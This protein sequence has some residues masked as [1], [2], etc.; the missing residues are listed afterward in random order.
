MQQNLGQRL[1]YLDLLRILATFAV[2]FLHACSTN[3]FF[4]CSNTSNWYITLIGDSLVRW[5][6][7]VFVMISGAL[8]LNP[9]RNVT[10]RDILTKRI[11]R[12][13][14]A[15]VFWTGI[16]ILQGYTYSGFEGF[17]V[18]RFLK[19]SAHSTA[20]LWFLPMLMG[21][22]FLIPVLHTITRDKK[23]MR[24]VLV[25]WIVL[26]FVSFLRFVELFKEMNHFY[27]LFNMNTVAGFSGYFIL[28]YYLSRQTFSKRQRMWIYLIG[29]AGALITIF[30]TIYISTSK[31]GG[32]ELFFNYFSIQVVAMA[33]SL[34]VF[35]KQL[36][37]GKI[38]Q[39]F[40][41]FV[42]KDL[43]GIYLVHALWLVYIN[44]ETVRHCCSVAI[45]LP[46]ITIATF[47]LSLFTIKLIRLI[48]VLRKVVE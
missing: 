40:V 39:R 32:D 10:Y 11:P 12:L 28:G 20:H 5:C 14:V 43:F 1:V 30:G 46:L 22:Y 48:P 45:T 47:V 15:Y 18:L 41:N 6:V 24:Y 33:V 35:V 37:C 17:T 8:F 7:P 27:G 13:L 19:R 26:V 4:V 42:R 21:V 31:K 44:T 36:N 23:T 16:Y 9:D 2:I 38:V 34:F 29:V 3:D 25:L